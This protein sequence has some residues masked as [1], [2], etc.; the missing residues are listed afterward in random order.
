MRN[1][2]Q[3]FETYQIDEESINHVLNINFRKSRLIKILLQY[4]VVKNLD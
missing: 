2:A 3:F 1:I 4:V